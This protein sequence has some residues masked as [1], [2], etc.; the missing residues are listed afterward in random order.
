MVRWFPTLA[1]GKGHDLSFA[2][3]RA[4][5]SLMSRAQILGKVSI[6]HILRSD[7]PGV[8]ADCFFDAE[9][10]NFL[11]GR[12]ELATKPLAFVRSEDRRA[13]DVNGWAA[14]WFKC[15]THRQSCSR[16]SAT[17]NQTTERDRR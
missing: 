15:F 14:N 11:C 7:H 2:H 16:P 8:L 9:V 5:L 12:N 10:R 3:F 6:G 4:R 1:Y 17:Y 13:E